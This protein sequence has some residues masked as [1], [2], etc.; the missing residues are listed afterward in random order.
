MAAR[1]ILAIAVGDSNNN[2]LIKAAGDVTAKMRPYIAGLIERLDPT[3]GGHYTIGDANDYIINYQE[4]AES[5]LVATITAQ[6]AANANT[7]LIFCM[8]T[9]VVWAAAEFTKTQQTALPIVGIVSDPQ[10]SGVDAPQNICGIS[11]QRSQLALEYYNNFL[12]TV[13]SLTK[14]YVLHKQGYLPSH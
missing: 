6:V 13:S 3:G 14:V 7:K 12:S 2:K 11:G 4:C 9:T 10:G 5:A 8:S 1:T